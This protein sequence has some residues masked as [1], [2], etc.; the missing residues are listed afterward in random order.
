ME[1]AMVSVIVPVYNSA[2]FLDRCIESVVR[3]TYKNIEV[4]LVDDGSSDGSGQICD[5]WVERDKRVVVVHKKNEGVSS[6]RN[7]GL[8]L[9]KGEFLMMLDSDDWIDLEM[10][11]IMRGHM[12]GEHVDC[13]ICGLQQTNGNIWAPRFNRTYKDTT[14][15]NIDFPYWLDSELLSSSVNKMYKNKGVFYPKGMSYGEDLVFVLDYLSRCRGISFLTLPLY[16]HEVQNEK[17]IT[18]TF[19]VNRFNDIERYQKRVLKYVLSSNE[20]QKSMC[21]KKYTKDSL[22]A[23]RCLFRDSNMSL[24]EKKRSLSSWYNHSYML[25][26]V[27]FQFFPMKDGV[28]SLMLRLRLYNSLSILISAVDFFRRGC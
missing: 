23:I 13:V 1:K 10:C 17:S 7:V 12:L 20:I 11:D 15:F 19:D 25:T 14:E 27:P 9:A 22:Y 21:F 4:I 8:S 28:V 5:K 2:R 16:K 26:E 18:H 6:A 3:Q 24:E